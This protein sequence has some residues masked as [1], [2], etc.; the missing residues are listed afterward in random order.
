M[1]KLRWFFPPIDSIAKNKLI[2]TAQGDVDLMYCKCKKEVAHCRE[3]SFNNDYHK[4][5][6]L[7]SFCVIGI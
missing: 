1:L 2:R 7:S 6:S 3:V 5:Q 4:A